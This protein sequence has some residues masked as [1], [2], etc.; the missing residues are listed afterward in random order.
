MNPLLK[1][2]SPDEIPMIRDDG[3]QW[4]FAQDAELVVDAMQQ[5]NKRLRQALL[6]IEKHQAA[7]LGEQCHLSTI[8]NIA[9]K[10]LLG[11]DDER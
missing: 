4:C 1:Y 10:A 5:E 9:N 6:S 11:C 2:A 8:W 3:G 7:S